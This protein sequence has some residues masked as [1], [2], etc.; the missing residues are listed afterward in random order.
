MMKTQFLFVAICLFVLSGIGCASTNSNLNGANVS[1][2]ETAK[3]NF[4]AGEKA[5]KKKEYDEAVTFFE[6]VRSKYPY[7]KYAALSD[8]RIADTYVAKDEWI[9]AADAYD[10]F[11]RF[12]PRHEDVA[13]AWFQ[14]A[15]C[16]YESA[17]SDFFIKPPSYSKDQTPSKEAI[18]AIDHFIEQFPNDARVAQAKEMKAVLLKKLADQDMYVARFYAKRKQWR[19]ASLRYGRVV[20][21]YPD[22]ESAVEALY[23]SAKI[24]SQYLGDKEKART[25][26]Q[27]LVE[28]HMDSSYV[29][30]AKKQLEKISAEIDTAPASEQE[31]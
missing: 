26:F 25:L 1:Y 3:Q 15:K 28:R 16:H 21:Q 23:E 4:E 6:H 20:E 18:K 10:F 5:L 22:S 31:N 30:D 17:P 8:L 11:I 13:Y 29:K 24:A 2:L 9:E 12:H 19:G 27:Q 7:S 14:I